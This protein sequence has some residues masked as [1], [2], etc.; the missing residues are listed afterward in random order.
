MIQYRLIAI[1]SMDEVDL[2]ETDEKDIVQ[3]IGNVRLVI[4]L[5]LVV[6]ML[7]YFFI[8]NFFT[9]LIISHLIVGC[10]LVHFSQ[11]PVTF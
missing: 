2:H 3:N 5:L 4:L 11:Q 8:K 9:I 7:G 10:N 1:L 6:L